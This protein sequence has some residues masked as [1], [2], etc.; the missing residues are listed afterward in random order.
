ML[1]EDTKNYIL[2]SSIIF[3][4]IDHKHNV[5]LTKEYAAKDIYDY[6]SSELRIDISQTEARQLDI[7]SY[8]IRLTMG[9][10]GGSYELYSESDGLLIVR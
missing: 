10:P 3:E 1:D 8:R 7:D 5:V 4:I 6:A 2:E 9:F